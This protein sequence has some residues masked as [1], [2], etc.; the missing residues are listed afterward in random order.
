MSIQVPTIYSQRRD[1]EVEISNLTKDLDE[2]Q[3]MLRGL[4]YEANAEENA[5]EI[6]DNLNQDVIEL[7]QRLDKAYY[8]LNSLEKQI[9]EDIAEKIADEKKQLE[10]LRKSVDN[11][12]AHIYKM[13]Q[14][15]VRDKTRGGHGMIRYHIRLD[16][17]YCRYN[18]AGDMFDESGY[19]GRWDG[20]TLD[21]SSP[22]SPATITFPEFFE[23]KEFKMTI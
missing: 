16:G 21:R 22:K 3:S 2:A 7:T 12:V 20:T 9:D 10:V 18:I 13:M 23:L 15:A 8:K 19:I 5:D 6:V 17:K 1:T 4:Q 11:Q 14:E